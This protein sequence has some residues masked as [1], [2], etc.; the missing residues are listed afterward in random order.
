MNGGEDGAMT[1]EKRGWWQTNAGR[2]MRQGTN[3]SLFP[4]YG[5]KVSDVTDFPG[6]R[7]IHALIH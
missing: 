6:S 4:W 5:N 3:F 2:V 7:T 1:K